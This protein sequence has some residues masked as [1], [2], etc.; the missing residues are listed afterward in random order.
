MDKA[1]ALTKALV[2]RTQWL[3]ALTMGEMK[4]EYVQV[5]EDGQIRYNAPAAVTTT[6]EPSPP[7]PLTL[8]PC[9]TPPD[10]SPATEIDVPE[11]VNGKRLESEL[12]YA[13]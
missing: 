5:L 13:G 3:R 2:E 1:D 12:A 9:I 10:E 11:A 4:L 7:E 8:E 6:I